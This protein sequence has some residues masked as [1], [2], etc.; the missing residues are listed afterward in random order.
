MPTKM[1]N[2]RR[3]LTVDEEP[4]VLDTLNEELQC[5]EIEPDRAS[6]CQEAIQGMSSL[7]YDLEVLDIMGVRGVE[8]LE[9]AGT[10]KL[11]VVMLTAH[12]LS[13]G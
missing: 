13:G 11:P 10:K 1:L 9:H 2:G 6:T 12:A 7:T 5:R 8:P 3:I 4:D